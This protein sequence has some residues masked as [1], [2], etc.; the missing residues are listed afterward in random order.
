M[1]GMSVS[2]GL[3]SGIDYDSMITQL[4]QIEANPQTLLKGRLSAAQKDAAA[5]RDINTTFAGL[6]TAAQAL[7]SDDGIVSA[8]SATSSSSAVTASAGTT[9]VPGSSASFTVAKLATAQT[10][11]SKATWSS[12]TADVRT[13]QP[14]WPLTVPDETGVSAGSIDVPAGAT[15]NDAAAAINKSGFGLSATVLQLSPTQ[16]KLQVASSTTG[17]DS[18][19]RLQAPGEDA[20]TAGS[21][22]TTTDPSDAQITIGGSLVAT[23]SSNTFS[24][25]ATGLSVT[26]SA[27]SATPTTV[28]VGTD[29]KAVTD[30][31]QALVTAANAVLDKIGQYTDTT[32][33]TT[34]VLKGNFDL[35]NLANQVLQTV[36]TAVTGGGATSGTN[37][38]V[39]T[40]GI[41]LTREGRLT[42]DASVFQAKL[43]ADPAVVQRLLGGSVDAGTDGKTGSVDDAVATDGLA[44]RL[45]V[46]A[47]RASDSTSGL[48][49]SLA[50]GQDSIGSDLQDQI[51]SW[52]LRLQLRK[53]A[54]TAQFSAMETVL[55]TLQSQGNWLAG[56]INSLPSWSSSKS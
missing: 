45:Q 32:A 31:V 56:Q 23:S 16:F 10:S 54:L 28:T 40:A 39:S 37:G 46:L 49:T 44:A 13:Q 3:I 14:G 2:T 4:M 26:V 48:L 25:L 41:Q 15:L 5:Y 22:F 55:G 36:S 53:D 20:T 18:K 50:K 6:L 43:A 24:E 27:T 35:T 1:A 7:T 9:A 34:A 8:R 29:T 52:D 17:A 38:S 21:A 42:F 19:F 12:R 30:K 33:G 51:D 11:V 47:Q